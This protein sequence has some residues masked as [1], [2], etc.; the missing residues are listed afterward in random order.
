MSKNKVATPPVLLKPDAIADGARVAWY[1]ALTLDLER[2]GILVTYIAER[3]DDIS[4]N[5][6]MTDPREL[7]ALSLIALGIT[8]EHHARIHHMAQQLFAMAGRVQ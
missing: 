6:E 8:R 7:E 5:G 1:D 4:T 2:A 3:L